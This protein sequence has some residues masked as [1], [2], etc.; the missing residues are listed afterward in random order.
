MLMTSQMIQQE[1]NVRVWLITA[2]IGVLWRHIYEIDLCHWSYQQEKQFSDWSIQWDKD[3]LRWIMQMENTRA[4]DFVTFEIGGFGAWG[5][6]V[7][8][9][10]HRM[11]F[12]LEQ[13][14]VK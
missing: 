6:V 9:N 2:G 14:I 10:M 4:I 3:V 11:S 12:V 1:S 8:V 13:S 7:A 5:V